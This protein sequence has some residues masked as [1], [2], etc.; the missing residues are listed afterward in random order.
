[1]KTVADLLST[2]AERKKG[3]APGPGQRLLMLPTLPG[4]VTP[5]PRRRR[6]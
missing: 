4:G 2:F 3:P 1:M 6:R 5:R